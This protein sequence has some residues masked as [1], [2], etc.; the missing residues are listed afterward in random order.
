MLPCFSQAQESL[1]LP[2]TYSNV[3][4]VDTTISAQQLYLRCRSWFAE[5]YKNSQDVIQMDDKENGKIIGKGNLEFFSKIFVGSS[6]TKGWIRY[7][8]S[9]QVKDGRYKYE[10]TNFNHEGNR[11][12]DCDDLSFGLLTTSIDC[13]DSIK[14]GLGK[15]W[16]NK[17]WKEIKE[18]IDNNI[19]VL[20]KSLNNS[21]NKPVASKENNW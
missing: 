11:Y 12:N 4:K 1:T 17:V 10:I 2:L 5:S 20:I 8:I 21:M 19:I 7:T 6:C 9:V 14:K 16:S 3:V 18:S 13:P 15:G